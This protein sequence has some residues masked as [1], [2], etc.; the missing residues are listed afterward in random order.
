[1]LNILAYHRNICNI[2]FETFSQYFWAQI[3]YPT[4]HVVK[5]ISLEYFK[6]YLLRYCCNIVRHFCV[7]FLVYHCNIYNM[8]FETFSQYFKAQI[9][10]PTKHMIK[11]I[12]L[13]YFKHIYCNIS[14]IPTKHFEKYFRYILLMFHTCIMK[15]F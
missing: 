3:C 5:H 15:R 1:M 10:Y 11:H 8:Y 9:C 7:T 14:A 2:Y 6:T 4:K 12:S 13:E